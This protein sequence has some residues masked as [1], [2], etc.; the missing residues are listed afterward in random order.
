MMALPV[1]RRTV[2][3]LL[4]ALV[5]L[6]FVASPARAAPQCERPVAAKE[7]L[8]PVNG[9]AQNPR[10]QAIAVS[11]ARCAWGIGLAM[12]PSN[13]GTAFVIGNR[14]E[15]MTNLHVVDKNCRGNTRFAFR[16]G[17]DRGRALSTQTA[18]VV[19][20]GDYCAK[21]KRGHH[22]YSGDWAIAVLD[23][24]PTDLEGQAPAADTRPMQPRAG[25]N[26]LDGN[27]GYFLLGYS[28]SFRAGTQ[29]YRSAPCRFSHL[30]S[31]DVVEH[32]C[33]AS[34]RSS[35]APIVTQDAAGNCLVA[36]IHVGEIAD[37]PGRPA[38]RD[39][40]NANVAVLASRFAP[41]VK[42][43]AR[44]LEQGRDAD[45]IAADLAAHP[46]AR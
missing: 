15:V 41:A 1:E 22:D 17:F 19:V 12:P 31:K 36:A 20:H 11:R 6:F 14:R 23:E 29:P 43:V 45:E 5:V 28:M 33:D 16:H 2:V 37:V 44:A 39:D 26:W 4:A 10:P 35:G 27:G 13:T 25:G 34:H 42:A 7:S 30:F 9:F 8:I 3:G 46:P 24:D 32:S 21:L 40:V 38:Y 18:T